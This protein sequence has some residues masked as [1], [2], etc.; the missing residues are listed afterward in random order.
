MVLLVTTKKC[1]FCFIYIILQ[2]N[3]KYELGAA[4]TVQGNLNRDMVWELIDCTLR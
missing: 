4:L 3:R 1:R 2:D